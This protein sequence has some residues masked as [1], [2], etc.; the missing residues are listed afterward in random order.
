M[1][2]TRWLFLFFPN[3][4]LVLICTGPS[5]VSTTTLLRNNLARCAPTQDHKASAIDRTLDLPAC[6]KINKNRAG[7]KYICW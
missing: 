4:L 7:K 2:H 1:I 5:T 6:S 3:T